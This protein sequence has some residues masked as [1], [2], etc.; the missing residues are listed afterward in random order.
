MGANEGLNTITGQLAKRCSA[1]P[2]ALE[3]RNQALDDAALLCDALANGKRH[4]SGK[5]D[6]M[7]DKETASICIA[8]ASSM[9]ACAEA[10]RSEKL[11][12]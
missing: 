11:K 10:I 1:S 7:G 5:Y 12:G 4:E 9:F 8:Q 6:D 3:I 2:I